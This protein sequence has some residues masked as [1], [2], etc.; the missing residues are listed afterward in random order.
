MAPFRSWLRGVRDTCGIGGFDAE[1]GER[2]AP[3][4][5]FVNEIV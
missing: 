2:D 5:L 4:L 3:G 1:N